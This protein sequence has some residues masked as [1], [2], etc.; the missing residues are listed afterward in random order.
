MQ[1]TSIGLHKFSECSLWQMEDYS[2][3]IQTGI[4]W[5]APTE[6]RTLSSAP[7]P[8]ALCTEYPKKINI[9]CSTCVQNVNFNLIPF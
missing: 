4:Y 7:Q 1:N 9:Q 6:Q 2:H 5:F 3:S 8:V